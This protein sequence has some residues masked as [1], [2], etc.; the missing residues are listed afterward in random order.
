L[1]S[2]TKGEVLAFDGKTLRHSF[3][4]AC[5]LPVIYMVSV[6]AERVRLVLGQVKI[7]EKSNEI[8][9]VPALLALL[10]ITGCMVTSDTMSCQ[11]ATAVQIISQG[12]DYVLAVKDNRPALAQA[13]LHRFEYVRSHRF[14]AADYRD[15]T[16]SYKG[17]G[18]IETRRCELITL[19][20]QDFLWGDLQQA[21]S[22][23]RSLACITCARPVG[24]KL[25]TEVRYS[26]SSLAG[27]VQ[28][29]LGAV[30]Q[31]W[32]IEN[33]LQYVLDV[34]LDEDACRI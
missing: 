34:S 25:S 24:E 3:D 17:H 10:D 21:W 5:G 20:E 14:E 9:A 31:H 16:Q 12:G 13:I 1:H 22:G 29:V 33:R 32:G 4:S 2:R 8:P 26:I 27:S 11:K 7:E 19:P 28:K 30:R 18:R 23:L 15:C 6:W